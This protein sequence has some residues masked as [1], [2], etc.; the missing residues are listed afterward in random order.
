MRLHDIAIVGASG[1]V[2]RKILEV[3]SERNFPHGKIIAIASDASAGKEILVKGMSYK[4]QRLT[5]DVFRNVEFAFFCAGGIVSHEYCP[6]AAKE[7]CIVIDNSSSFRMDNDVPLVVPEVNRNEI[8]RNKGIIANPNCS[9]IQLVVV[10]KPLDDKFKIKRVVV[11]TYQ[12]VSGAGHKGVSSLEAEIKHD[13]P[14]HHH[15]E[16]HPFPHKIAY[17]IIPQVDIFFDDGYTKE[18][19]KM[20]NETK[21]ILGK[22]D[23]NITATCVR[24]PVMVGHSESV[25]IEFEKKVSPADVKDELI[26]FR[27]ITVFDDPGNNQYPMPVDSENKDDVFVGRIRQDNSIK[28]GINMWVVSDNVRKGAATNAV[29]IAEE[30]LKGK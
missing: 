8:F 14:R 21:K 7:G 25:N 29:Q 27:G 17:N 6:I 20:I 4:L 18:E 22:K 26:G 28:N 10:L 19:Y 1:L 12:S 16:L 3:L 15:G 11:S 30:Y 5:H 2:G 24:V 23:F 9:T 13:N